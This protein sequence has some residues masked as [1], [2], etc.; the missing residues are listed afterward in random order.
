MCKKCLQKW[1]LGS[2]RK[3]KAFLIAK[4]RKQFGQKISEVSSVQP[5]QTNER[6]TN[7]VA[8]CSNLISDFLCGVNNDN[9]IY[10]SIQQTL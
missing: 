5:A 7:V 10:A 3:S 9:D 2:L 6:A 8:D 1:I 4:C